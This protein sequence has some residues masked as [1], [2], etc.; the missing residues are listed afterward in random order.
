LLQRTGIDP[1]WFVQ[2][3]FAGKV[4]VKMF[5]SEYFAFL[6][7]RLILICPYLLTYS[8]VQSPS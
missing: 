1:R 3:L 8:I 5:L 4:T 7:A 6:L 2:D